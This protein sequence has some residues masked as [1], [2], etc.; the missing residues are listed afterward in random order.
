MIL[1]QEKYML[2]DFARDLPLGESIVSMIQRIEL[3]GPTLLLNINKMQ[4]FPF[5]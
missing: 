3:V 5:L 4:F 1:L 2:F